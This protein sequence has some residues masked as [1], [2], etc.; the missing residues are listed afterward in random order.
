MGC[1]YTMLGI[2][3]TYVYVTF[4]IVFNRKMLYSRTKPHIRCDILMTLN[5]RALFFIY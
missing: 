1:Q 2:K 4:R 3:Y 5:A